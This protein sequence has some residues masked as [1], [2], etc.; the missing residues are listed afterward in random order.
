MFGLSAL[1][2]PDEWERFRF[3]ARRVRSLV[4]DYPDD[5]FG[6]ELRHK[7]STR[8]LAELSISR[9]PTIL[10]PNLQQLT[11]LD[12]RK[13]A[14]SHISLFLSPTLTTLFVSIRSNTWAK[15]LYNLL[16]SHRTSLRNIEIFGPRLSP[17]RSTR[18]P[19]S[20]VLAT[21]LD[22]T[23]LNFRNGHA[24]SVSDLAVLA[25][26]RRL[27]KLAA[28]FLCDSKPPTLRG[29]LST[30][31]VCFPS[32]QCFYVKLLNPAALPHIA[33]M[34]GAIRSQHF[35]EL[36][37]RFHFPGPAQELLKALIAH[38]QFKKLTLMGPIGSD[39]VG[40][41]AT[42]DPVFQLSNLTDFTLS[43]TTNTRLTRPVLHKM[44]H[45]WPKIKNLSWRHSY[46]SKTPPLDIS[47]L[48]I[49]AQ[50]C[51]DLTYIFIPFHS[52]L[53]DDCT[54]DAPTRRA[55]DV[56]L[57]VAH[58]SCRFD[59]AMAT[60]VYLS[61]MFP[62]VDIVLTRWPPES[63]DLKKAVDFVKRLRAQE[64]MYNAS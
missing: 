31:E 14:Q 53:N 48:Q 10:L 21:W 58:E 4:C 49:L 23:D 36:T 29:K 50:C 3:Y 38:A 34:I 6:I 9:P 39:S 27:Q 57:S 60:A 46:D 26:C 25:K 64:R 30:Q 7:T 19:F 11:W 5:P 63:D 1:P 2:G 40:T 42:L 52:T 41:S 45:S 35:E 20:K 51:P 15:R 47:D 18:A 56:P 28:S 13:H 54:L 44:A 61:S 24:I 8:L 62:A 22:L 32:L 37:A 59:N 12:R 17:S 43:A 55:S 33:E 16:Y